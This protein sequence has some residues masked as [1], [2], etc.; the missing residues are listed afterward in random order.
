MGKS[1][2]NDPVL[3]SMTDF[4]QYAA[5]QCDDSP[6]YLFD[7]T[8]EG[9]KAELLDEYSEPPHIRGRFWLTFSV[10]L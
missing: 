7:D 2:A 8:F 3:L 10:W 1:R 5:E 4:E 6:L 9:C